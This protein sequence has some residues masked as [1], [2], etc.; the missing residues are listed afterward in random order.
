M[1]AFTLSDTL[2]EEF[3][4]LVPFQR[5]VVDRLLSEGKLVTYAL[6]M[7][8]SRLWAVFKANSEMEVLDMIA[9]FPLAKFM[10]VKVSVL[11]FYNTTNPA[12]PSFSLN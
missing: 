8:E 7:E 6:S 12:M 9:D 4:K 2:S 5:L 11:N 3:M 1:A 10:K